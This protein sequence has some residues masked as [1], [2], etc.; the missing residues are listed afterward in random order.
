MPARSNAALTRRRLGGAVLLLAGIAVAAFVLWPSGV[1][2][3]GDDH[4]AAQKKLPVRFVSVPPLGLV[5]AHPT[6]WQRTV[7]KRVIGLRAP[8]GSVL[9]YFSSPVAKPARREVKA[10]AERQLRKQFAPAKI[11]REGPG[12]LG[13]RTVS[14]FELRGRSKAGP[15]RAL[16]LVDSTDYRT[17]AVTVLTGPKPS[18]RRLG[19]ARAIISTVRLGKPQALRSK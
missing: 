13:D 9:V 1:W 14:S 7:R 16:V 4:S 19:E 12:R 18:R 8:G 10:A 6:S 17:Y 15:V 3:R 5:F 2:P 11:V